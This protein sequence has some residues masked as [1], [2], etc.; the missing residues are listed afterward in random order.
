M[1]GGEKVNPGNPVLLSFLSM[2]VRESSNTTYPDQQRLRRTETKVTSFKFY[3]NPFPDE[4]SAE[5]E[6]EEISLFI[7]RANCRLLAICGARCL[8]RSYAIL[9]DWL[10]I[11]EVL[12][13]IIEDFYRAKITIRF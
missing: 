7:R 6:A 10:K 5:V 13:S 1:I 4:G 11:S 2:N 12:G 3:P 8:F 9:V